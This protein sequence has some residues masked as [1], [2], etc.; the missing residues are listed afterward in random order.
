M[1]GTVK[2]RSDHRLLD[3]YRPR[4]RRTVGACRPRRLRHRPQR[5]HACAAPPNSARARWRSTCASEGLDAGRREAGGG[6]SRQA[7]L[8]AGQQRRL[9]P[10]RS[11]RVGLDGGGPAAVPDERV[12][13][14]PDVPKAGVPRETRPAL[15]ADREHQLDGRQL[16]LPRSR[17]LPRHQVR[18]RGDQRRP[19]V[20]GEG[21]RGRGDRDP[22]RADPDPTSARPP[23]TRWRGRGKRTARAAR[24]CTSSSTGMSPR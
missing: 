9:F 20:R 10:G 3:R 11:G 2:S 7:C 19:A 15:R 21:L 13:S 22:A 16:H 17:P 24:G 12:R 1:A 4:H 18:R 8:G 5:D 23:P 14:H 6:P